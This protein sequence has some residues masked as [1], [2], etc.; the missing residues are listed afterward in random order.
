MLIHLFFIKVLLIHNF[1]QH[2]SY[3]IHSYYQAPPCPSAVTVDQH[4]KMSSLMFIASPH[5]IALNIPH[6]L[7]P[8]GLCSCQTLLLVY[9]SP[10]CIPGQSLKSFKTWPIYHPFFV[11]SYDSCADSPYTVHTSPTALMPHY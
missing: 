4:S 5:C 9:L 8:L 2:C 11:T 6:S 3:N 10:T 1:E 7:M